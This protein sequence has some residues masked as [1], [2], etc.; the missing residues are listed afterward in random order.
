LTITISAAAVGYNSGF[1]VDDDP[2]IP[3]TTLL[4]LVAP[5]GRQMARPIQ[6]VVIVVVIP[7]TSM[8]RATIAFGSS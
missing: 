3:A 7:A 8:T 2:K 4:L 1:L 6:L 5:T